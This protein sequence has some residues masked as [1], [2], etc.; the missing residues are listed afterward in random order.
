M[1]DTQ[2]V[3]GIVE[4]I[5]GPDLEK[6][7]HGSIKVDGKFYKYSNPDYRNT[8]WEPP[9]SVGEAVH[10]EVQPSEYEGKTTWWV[11]AIAVTQAATTESVAVVATSTS[12]REDSIARSVAL[13]AAVDF[14]VAL[15]GG[16][17]SM[18]EREDVILTAEFFL[19]FLQGGRG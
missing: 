19:T 7:R 13:K 3:D 8:P 6:K 15:G 16:P 5:E 10:M 2:P 12:D 4:Q 17:A 1:T 14:H 11:K 9:S 18:G